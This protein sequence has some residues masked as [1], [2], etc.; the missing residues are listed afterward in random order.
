[1]KKKE[2]ENQW[3]RVFSEDA[4]SSQR[5]DGRTPHPAAQQGGDSLHLPPVVPPRAWQAE[6]RK[7]PF[8]P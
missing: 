4:R 2:K 1:L 7:K 6:P 5:E 3:L 8:S